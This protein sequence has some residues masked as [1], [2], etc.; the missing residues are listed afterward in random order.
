[1]EDFSQ[2]ILLLSPIGLIGL[3]R[4]G[5]WV[6]KKICA[7]SYKPMPGANPSLTGITLSVVTPVYNEDPKIFKLAL[8]SWQANSPDEI[9]AVIDKT[10]EPCIK[11]FSNFARGKPGAKLI[12]TTK[13]GK[14]AALADG[15]REATREIVALVDSDTIWMSKVRENALAPFRNPDIGG[16]VTRQNCSSPRSIWQKMTDIMWDLRNADEWQSQTVMGKVLT[17]LSGRTAFYR[18]RILL[19]ILDK[20]QNE[21]IFGRKKESGDD[22]CLTR[23]IQKDGWMSYYQ[24]NAQVYSTAAASFSI[25]WK[26]RVRWSRNSFG[27]DLTALVIERWV[28]KHPFLAFYMI[29]R[30]ISPFTLTI[31]LIIFLI[32]VY[33]NNWIVAIGI[34]CWWILSRGVKIFP[35]LKRRP[36]DILLLPAYAMINFLVA[37]ARIYALVTVKEQKW[38]RERMET[39][40]EMGWNIS[41]KQ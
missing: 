23:L 2:Y 25:F 38:I 9:I 41:S 37:F 12:I 29:D 19:P 35:H 26:Q 5:V 24:S 13:P 33:L 15:I 40:E 27:S 7:L 39:G 31:G 36:Q 3:W 6:F 22:K 28:W 32:A 30:F 1:M 11:I 20:F 34:L 16:V 4:W 21:I 18:R 14:R 17:C 10:A 8:D